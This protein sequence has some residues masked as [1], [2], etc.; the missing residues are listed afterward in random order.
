MAEAF[1]LSPMRRLLI[2]GSAMLA[3]MAVAV[4]TTIANVA[5][6]QIQAGMSASREQVV[7]VLTSYLIASAI[8]TP[9]SGWLASRYGRKMVMVAS[10]AGFTIASAGCGLANSLTMLVVAR[11][12]QGACGAGL[13]PLSQAMLIDINP[14]ER[15]GRAMA[16]YGVGTM[17]GPLIGPTLGGW[18]TDSFSW[19]WV[20]FVNLPLGVLSVTG[21]MLFMRN[22]REVAPAR[23]DRFGFISLSVFL[24]ALQLML[25]RGQQLDWFD[26]TEVRIEAAVMALAGY[27]TMVHMFTT[28]DGFIRPRMFRDRN[29][30]VGCML[31]AAIG[32]ISFAA[33][34]MVTVMMEQLLGYSAMQTG[35]VSSPR[36]IGT[37]VSMMV[38]G[39]MIGRF[40][41]RVFLIMGLTLTTIGLGMLAH[42][43][44][45]TGQSS[46]LIA[47]A[48]QG[49]G[50]GL[51]MVPLSSMVFATLAPGYRNEGAAL[52]ALTRNIGASLGISYLQTVT[53]HN[54]AHV[55]A[56]L[57]EAVRPDNPMLGFAM[58]ALDFAS[59]ERLAMMSGAIM[60]QALMVAY[61]DSFWLLSLVAVAMMPVAL[62]MRPPRGAL[63]EPIA[64][65]E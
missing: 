51:M 15:L 59:P 12:L 48:F 22:R 36:G 65:M 14:P 20:F 11:F 50:S 24:A 38:V 7:W 62:L 34:P 17:F 45:M 46:L 29:F 21:M 8:A 35:M 37:L 53:F 3:T 60:R 56:R 27:Q 26:S 57:V 5:L 18:L 31:S 25:D 9:L 49:L 42:L 19:R 40:D 61:S 13:I 1:E 32:I 39:R 30:G 44:L 10:A 4:D 43:N 16:I 28:P 2:T 58:P 47:G 23:F 33:I 63:I 41:T 54:T 6:P 55:Q 64:V 52:Y